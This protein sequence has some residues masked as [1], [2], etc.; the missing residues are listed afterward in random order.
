MF[1][2][3]QIIGRLGS[4]PEVRYTQKQKAVASFNVATTETWKEKGTGARKERTEWHHVVLFGNLAEI[5][6]DHLK[7][8]ALVFFE[9]PLRTRKWQD[10]S[11]HDRYITEI[12]AD[13]MKM[14]GEKQD[15]S[16]S[17]VSPSYGD[18]FDDE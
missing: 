15:N 6:R 1:N 18:N 4:D 8:G 5:A 7:K 14:L 13:N 10:Q 3:A 2:K 16:S 17:N 12:H 11:G 9:G